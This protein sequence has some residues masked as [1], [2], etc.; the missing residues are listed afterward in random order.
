M[1]TP[2]AALSYGGRT[3]LAQ[4]LAT[5]HAGGVADV[6]VVTGA[7]HDAAVRALPHDV[8][9]TLARNPEPE[10]GQLSSLKVGLR[11]AAEALP[12]ASA[13]LVALVDHPAV[14]PTTVA[15]LLRVAASPG[16]AIVL[17]V[18]GGRRGHPVV[19]AR[20]V[21]AELLATPDELGARAV[22]RADPARV[23][24]V[25]VEDPGILLDVDT[26]EDLRRLRDTRR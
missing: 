26:P 24:E 13:A 17:P 19:F 6:V 10:R 7:A 3:F 25:A 18:H 12:H 2:K 16:A 23:R 20:G 15:A 14:R 22:L 11:Q 9:V 21:W 8:A 4:V 5:L 1:G